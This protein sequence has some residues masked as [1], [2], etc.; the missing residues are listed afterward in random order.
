MDAI[1]IWQFNVDEYKSFISLGHINTTERQ[2]CHLVPQLLCCCILHQ[3]SCT[4]FSYIVVDSE[5][6]VFCAFYFVTSAFVLVLFR[7]TN[8]LMPSGLLS[9]MCCILIQMLDKLHSEKHGFYYI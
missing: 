8:I 2:A 1:S 7:L 3:F 5:I 4:V 6:L 9:N